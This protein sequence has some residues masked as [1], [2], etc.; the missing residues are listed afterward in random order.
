MRQRVGAN[1]DPVVTE[2]DR[3]D[4]PGLVA[5]GVGADPDPRGGCLDGVVDHL[6]DRGVQIKTGVAP[7]FKCLVDPNDLSGR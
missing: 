6:A 4:D 5:L 3:I 1:P 2:R 7:R